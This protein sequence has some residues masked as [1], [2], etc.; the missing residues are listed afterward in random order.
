M[1]RATSDV[2]SVEEKSAE[3][4]ASNLSLFARCF[5][6][7]SSTVSIPGCNQ[8]KLLSELNRPSSSAAGPSHTNHLVCII[9]LKGSNI[10]DFSWQKLSHT[11]NPSEMPLMN[12]FSQVFF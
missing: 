1:S 8:G 7:P 11:W 5:N 6:R 3:K 2:T 9:L 12:P 4:T 10:I